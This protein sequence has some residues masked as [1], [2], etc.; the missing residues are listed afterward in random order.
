M[1]EN[2]AYFGVN[3]AITVCE[4][5]KRSARRIE[6]LKDGILKCEKQGQLIEDWSEGE[7]GSRGRFNVLQGARWCRYNGE[8]CN[9]PGFGNKSQWKSEQK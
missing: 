2:N 3:L 5:G 9:N 1:G 6:G 7:C 8:P 4:N